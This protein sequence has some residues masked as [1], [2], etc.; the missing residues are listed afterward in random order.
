MRRSIDYL[1]T[2]IDHLSQRDHAILADLE[3]I[4]VLTGEHLQRLHF[5]EIS[6]SA[7]GRDRRRVLQ[8]LTHHGFVSTLD[9][10]IGGIRA[11]STGHVYTLAPTA[12]RLFDMRHDQPPR[13]ALRSRTPGPLFLNHALATSEIYVTLTETSRANSFQVSTFDTEPVCWH[14][15]DN[16]RYLKPDAYV[17][18]EATTHKDCWWLE[19][20][21]ATETRPRIKRKIQSYL[22]HLTTGGTGPDN[23]PPRI[24]FTTPNTTRTTTIGKVITPLTTAAQT[25][26]VICVTTHTDAPG[27][28]IKELA[29]P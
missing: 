11:G 25:D 17:V 27:F 4:R 8:R 15:I 13:R 29:E 23:L 9:R 2:H 1:A 3:R 5:T 19:I 16:N 26:Q 18:L 7:R 12:R 24:L 28:L 21:Q 6:A 10:R 14:R 20:D 22:D